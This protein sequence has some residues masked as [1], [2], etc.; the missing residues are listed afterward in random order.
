MA[1]VPLPES[2]CVRVRL[3]YNAGSST[4]GGN[5]FYLS[6][7]DAAPSGANCVTL[8]GDI[9]TAWSANLASVA[10][11]DWVLTE[12]DVLDIATDSGLSGQWTGS[13]AGTRSGNP[14]A[15]NTCS[16]VEYGISRRYRGGK[17]RSYLPP[18]VSGDLA[19][20][21]TWSADYLAEIATA[22]EGFY[23]AIAALSIGS[24][25]TLAHVNLSYYA[26]Y[27]KTT[28]PWRGPGFKYPPLYRDTALVETIT[29]Y[30]PKSVV[31]SQRR[32]RT[33]TSP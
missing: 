33:A 13:E 32:R 11:T 21:A 22:I 10:A 6:Y 2:P 26:G 31:G 23:A 28:P 4:Q 17:P 8:A 20:Q 29:G 3:D 7:S 30:F 9:A 27:A 24:M 16:N 25:G 1:T 5:R 14:V 12:I 19:T 18:G 15:A